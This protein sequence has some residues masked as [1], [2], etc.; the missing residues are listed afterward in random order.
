[1]TRVVP[2][3]ALSCRRSLGEPLPLS[4]PLLTHLWNEGVRFT[5]DYSIDWRLLLDKREDSSTRTPALLGECLQGL[6]IPSPLLPALIYR[7]S[8]SAQ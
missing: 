2:G 8:N 6:Q 3:P 1:M 4:G 5:P 7:G